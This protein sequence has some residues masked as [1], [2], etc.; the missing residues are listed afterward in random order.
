MVDPLSE[1]FRSVRLTGGIFLDARF[2]A[3]WCVYTKVRSEDC[4]LFLAAPSQIIAYHFII[5]GSLFVSVGVRPRCRHT[6]A[7]SCS[8]PATMRT[9]WP[10]APAL[11]LR[12]HVT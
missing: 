6:G 10:A 1:V 9:P 7:R 11:S 4:R 3:P 12:M 2:T 8:C 5:E